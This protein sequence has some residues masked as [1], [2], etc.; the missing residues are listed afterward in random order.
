MTNECFSVCHWSSSWFGNQLLLTKP[1]SR[2][3]NF[4]HHLLFFINFNTMNDD[5]LSGTISQFSLIIR[6]VQTSKIRNHINA[7]SGCIPGIHLKISN[8]N[9]PKLSALHLWQDSFHKLRSVA[10]FV[11][12]VSQNLPPQK[13]ETTVFK[14]KK[15]DS[16]S[17]LKPAWVRSPSS[18]Q[19]NRKLNI[20]NSTSTAVEDL[21]KSPSS[22]LY[23]PCGE[24]VLSASVSK[25]RIQLSNLTV[26]L[27]FR[28]IVCIY[29]R[30]WCM[31]KG[32]SNFTHQVC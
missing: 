19:R 8:K 22:A 25:V 10:V 1:G 11:L 12:F 5:W 13:K 29:G 27:N 16:G 4:C 24:I 23:G 15:D 3:P 6:L 30:W 21:I 14:V 2:P 32:K 28:W 26:C 20:C 31:L 17:N 18:A 7:Q 9:K